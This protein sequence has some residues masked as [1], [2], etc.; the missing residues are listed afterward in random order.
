[1]LSSNFFKAASNLSRIVNATTVQHFRTTSVAGFSS[2]IKGKCKF[3]DAV[4]G[5]GFISPDDGSEDVFVH[6]TEI[7]ATG[8][9]SLKGILK[10]FTSH[11]YH[12]KL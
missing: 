9:R 2:V 4:K 10:V 11:F 3:F 8:F 1:M 7:K 12:N 5:F 6:Q